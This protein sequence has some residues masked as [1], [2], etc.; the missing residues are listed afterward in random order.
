[1]QVIVVS[2]ESPLTLI[3]D[4]GPVELFACTTV[5]AGQFVATRFVI[6]RKSPTMLDKV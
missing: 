2:A 5:N 4:N 1:M 6:A 3:V